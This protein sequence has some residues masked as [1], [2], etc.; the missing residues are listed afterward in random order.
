MIR[1]SLA[2]GNLGT[3]SRGIVRVPVPRI[4]VLV[5]LLIALFAATASRAGAEKVLVKA[6]TLSLRANPS[7]D[8]QK[9]E[10]LATFDAVDVQKRQ[11]EWALVKTKSSKLGWVLEKYL[12]PTVF[13]TADSD[14]M[15]VRR[16]PGD[17]YEVIMKV[18]KHY[19]LKVLDHAEGWLKISDF[20][21]DR[22]WIQ[23][24]LASF[25]P[26]VITKGDKSNV[27]T[28]PKSDNP[29]AF[30]SEKG[31]LLKVLEQKEGWLKVKHEDGDEGWISAKIVF[32]WL[33]AEKSEPEK[34]EEKKSE[35]KPEKKSETKDE[36][37]SGK[38][39]EK[40]AEKKSQ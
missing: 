21:G 20:E 33:D 27:R 17:N 16:G 4:S 11:G 12:S 1:R 14:P 13:I 23:Q 31:V 39:A 32:G 8:A 29:I 28:G 9:L 22:G 40:K 37:K 15:N 10:T 26:Y 5:L 30:T 7:G 36:G 35:K 2:S 24:K 34:K 25:A 3:G 19:P 6:E 18:G 38:T